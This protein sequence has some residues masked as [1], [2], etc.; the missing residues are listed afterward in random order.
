VLYFADLIA[1]SIEHILRLEARGSAVDRL[2]A[3]TDAVLAANWGYDDAVY[4]E[5]STCACTT[6]RSAASGASGSCRASGSSRSGGS[7]CASRAACGPRHRGR[8][9]EDQRKGEARSH[10]SDDGEPRE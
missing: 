6:G 1:P 10:E 2:L 5:T 3:E 8:R 7:S 9:V 4:R